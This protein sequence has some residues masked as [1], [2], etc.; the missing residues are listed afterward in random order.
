M[1]SDHQDH[2]DEASNISR[3]RTVVQVTRPVYSESDFQKDFS[4]HH[5]DVSGLTLDNMRRKLRKIRLTPISLWQ[6]LLRL[7]PILK[8]LPSYNVRRDLLWDTVSGLT[9]AVMRVPQG[10]V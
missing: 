10:K 9:T 7:V 4:S 5:E 8:W 6:F 1:S 3:K 2:E